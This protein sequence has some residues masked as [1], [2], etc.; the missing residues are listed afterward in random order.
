MPAQAPWFGSLQPTSVNVNVNLDQNPIPTRLARVKGTISALVGKTMPPVDISFSVSDE[1][2]ELTPDL[3]I[4]LTKAELESG[5]VQYAI[6]SKGDEAVKQFH[7]WV[8]PNQALPK[9]IVT[10]VAFVDEFSQE[11][12]IFSGMAFNPNTS[13]SAGFG[14]TGRIV[15]MRF[16][17]AADVHE[18]AVPFEIKDLDVPTFGAAAS[19]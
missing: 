8:G 14:N 13:G 15:T 3:S 6:E 7:G 12:E 17:A 18:V 11:H 19:K 4:R 16:A 5:S 10:K 2:T 1:W 9:A